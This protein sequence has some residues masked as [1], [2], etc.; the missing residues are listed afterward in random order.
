MCDLKLSSE[1][2]QTA[3]ES[4][5]NRALKLDM[6]RGKPCVEQL[7]LSGCM[8]SMPSKGFKSIDGTDCRN[9]GGIDGIAEAKELFAQFL[10][11]LPKEI[12]I[13]GNSSLSMMYD[14]VVRCLLFGVP[15]SNIPW[16]S[17]KTKFLCPSPG[18]DRHFAIC[19]ALGI[20]MISVPMLENGPDMSVVEALLAEDST[21]RGMWCV[22]KYSNPTG[23]IYSSETIEL[24]A[25][26]K[27]AAPDFRIFWDNA[28]VIHHL[29]YDEQNAQQQMSILEA[30]KKFKNPNRV[31]MFGSTSKITFAGAGIA[32]LGASVTNIEHAKKYLAFQT[33]GPD[34][35]N[36]LRHV[37]FFE[38]F[39]G[40]KAHAAKHA[41]IIKPK[42]EAVLNTLSRELGS[43]G[44]ATWSKPKGGYFISLDLTRSSATKVVA[45]CNEL[46]VKMTPAGS[47]FPYGKDP[48]DKNIRIAPTLPTLQEVS[49][50]TEVLA[51]CIKY[52]SV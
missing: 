3:L 46:G 35:I 47:T 28:Y 34:K 14:T 9:Y 22:P 6:T 15:S 45:L 16:S 21:I 32:F 7:D 48:Q 17:L 29:D 4:W 30:C 19:E 42:F 5:K 36:Q 31:I 40:V 38:T 23:A 8:L 27:T 18:Y 39:A 20:E 10:D 1:N 25:S 11:I 49:T 2:I 13:G 12:I 24:L 41:K 51:L 26:M 44:L 37:E 50:A 43:S 52:C 33:I